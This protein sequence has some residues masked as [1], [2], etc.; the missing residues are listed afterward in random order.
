MTHAPTWPAAPPPFSSGGRHVVHRTAPGIVGEMIEAWLSFD[1]R[2]RAGRG[3]DAQ[4][5][6]RLRRALRA[7]AEE[8]A[9]AD[10]I[11]RVGANALVDVFPATE[12]NAA[13]Y[14]GE[15][16]DRIM[17][18]AYELHDLVGACVALRDPERGGSRAGGEVGA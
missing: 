14:A 1:D 7:C 9:G 11:P 6:E 18:A 10:A 17:G 12:A 13:L 5:Y 4:A 16:A 3:L 8:W 15:E 2:L